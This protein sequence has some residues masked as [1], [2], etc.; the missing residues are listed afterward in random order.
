VARVVER[1]PL[2][3]IV[4]VD[5]RYRW[6]VGL[7]ADLGSRSRESVE[8][9]LTTRIQLRIGEPFIRLTI[10]YHNQ[11]IDH[12]LRLHVPLA[13]AADRSFAEGQFA[14]V[15]RGLEAEAGHGEYP[16]P[17]YP[18]DA[19]VAAGGVAVLARHIVEYEL[20]DEGRVLAITLLRATGSI[21]RDDHPYRDEPAGPV[22]ATPGAQLPGPRTFELAI[23]P[24]AGDAP[25]PEVLAAA[26]VYRQPFLTAAGG[27]PADAPLSERPG[28]T[29]DGPG[30]V[31]SSLRRRAGWLE[32]RI[33]AEGPGPVSA[34]L[35]GPFAEARDADI[36]GRPGATLSLEDGAVAVELRPW[37][38]RTIQ[39][40]TTP[41]AT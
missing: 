16:L 14:I 32:A 10:T 9:V 13:Q 12:R 4:E 6:P 7:A 18:A 37:E 38:I 26:E 20:V 40:R 41:D 2:R 29:I 36:L 25:G 34:R 33:V 39:L 19:F 1:G 8:V 17:T 31:L 24:F 3:G 11:A 5:R 28:L 30:V 23:M 35:H 15:E 22:L 27:G 21:S